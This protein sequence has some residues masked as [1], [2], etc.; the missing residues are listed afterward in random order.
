VRLALS[1]PVTAIIDYDRDQGGFVLSKS[2]G[3]RGKTRVFG[4]IS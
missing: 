4:T 1:C 2:R 3:T